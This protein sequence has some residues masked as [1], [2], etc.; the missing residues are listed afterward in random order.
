[1]KSVPL[2]LKPYYVNLALRVRFVLYNNTKRAAE[3][4]HVT[5]KNSYQRNLSAKLAGRL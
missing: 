4:T 1:M 5:A 3:I 2:A